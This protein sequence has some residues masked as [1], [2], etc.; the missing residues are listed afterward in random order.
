MP[1]TKEEW[2]ELWYEMLVSWYFAASIED[3]TEMNT[4]VFKAKRKG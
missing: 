2:I 4:Y 1:E 3:V